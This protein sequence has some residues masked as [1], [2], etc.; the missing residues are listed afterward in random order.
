MRTLVYDPENLL[1]FDK[2]PTGECSIPDPGL[3]RYI[4]LKAPF[5]LHNFGRN[6]NKR[7]GK[8]D[9]HIVERFIN[10]LMISGKNA[11]KKHL[12]YNVV[13]HAFDLIHARTGQN[14]LQ[15]FLSALDNAAPREETTRISYGGIVYHTSVDTAPQRRVDLALSYLASGASRAAFNNVNTL[16]ECVADELLLASRNDTKAYSIKRK[17][18]IER[19]ARSAR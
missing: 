13:K 10:R 14:P 3:Q 8:A 6:A 12:L 15:I 2:W 16:E 4:T 11:G 17:L 1:L 19:V 5:A 7:F 18:E 9:T